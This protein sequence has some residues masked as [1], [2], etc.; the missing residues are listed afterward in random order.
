MEDYIY[1]ILEYLPVRFIDDEANEFL[2]YLTETYIENVRNRKYQ[3]SFIAFHMLYMTFIYKVK[4]LFEKQGDTIIEATLPNYKKRNGSAIFNT[5][6]DLSQLPEKTSLKE[7]LCHLRFHVNEIGI[8]NNHVDVRNN[9]CHASGKIYYKK[10]SRVGSYIEE[11]LEMVEKIQKKI[12]PELRKLIEDFLSKNWRQNFIPGDI[13]NWLEEN[14]LSQKDLETL[15]SF[16]LPLFKRK[17]DNAKVIYQKILYLGFVDEAQKY[18]GSDANIFLERLPIFMHGIT[19]EVRISKEGEEK[20]ESIHK[21]VAES[22]VPL[23]SNLMEQERK[24]AEAI[25]SI[26]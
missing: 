1:R 7:L 14:N 11:E 9:C 5:L 3:I 15:I 10:F 25:I 8:C 2:K 24:K 13:S 17:S 21:I 16:E 12:Q 20:L 22:L 4:W 26:R 23:V 6:F 19:E 18:I